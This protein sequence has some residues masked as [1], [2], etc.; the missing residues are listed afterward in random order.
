MWD[1]VMQPVRVFIS[2]PGDLFPERE[3]IKRVLDE[4]DD[5]PNYKNKYKFIPYAWEDSVPAQIGEGAQIV[6]DRYLLEPSQ[7][8]IFVCM[9][10]LRMGTPTVDWIDQQTGQPFH[11]GT[12]YEFFSAYDAY[13][14]TKAR[15]LILLY[16]CEREPQGGLKR[17]LQDQQ[18]RQQYDR[19]QGF[20]ERFEA[21][22]D[23]RAYIAGSIQKSLW[24]RS[25]ATI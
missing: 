6:V 21:N 12:E 4:L 10:W 20:F 15:P 22:G 13:I 9:M 16:R 25:F 18:Q 5:Q 23:L 11:S 14:E 19:V 24:R 7:A 2:S 8:D 1:S 3:V 17:L